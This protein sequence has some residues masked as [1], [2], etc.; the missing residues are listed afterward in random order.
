MPHPNSFS[1]SQLVHEGFKGALVAFP[2][3]LAFMYTDIYVHD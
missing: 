1:T 2:T 3:L